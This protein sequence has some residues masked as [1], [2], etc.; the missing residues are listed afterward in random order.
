MYVMCMYAYY[1]VYF[2]HA[3]QI[4]SQAMSDLEDG[5]IFSD[6]HLEGTITIA[7]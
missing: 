5:P 6:E 3:P 1:M 7:Q 4:T 2:V